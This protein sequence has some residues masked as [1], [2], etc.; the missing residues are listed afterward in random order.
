MGGDVLSTSI[1]LKEY[2]E[3]CISYPGNRSNLFKSDERE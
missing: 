1:M 3:M 2:V